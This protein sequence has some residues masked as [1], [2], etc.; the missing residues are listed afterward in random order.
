MFPQGSE[1]HYG[2]M[3][4]RHNVQW[5]DICKHNPTMMQ[6]MHAYGDCGFECARAQLMYPRDSRMHFHPGNHI[7]P[8]AMVVSPGMQFRAM[9]NWTQRPE[10]RERME[11]RQRYSYRLR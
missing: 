11:E 9:Y 4:P 3:Y 8:R 7:D 5:P 1:Q 2:I 6:R 10:I